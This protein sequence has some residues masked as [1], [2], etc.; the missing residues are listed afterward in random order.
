M[1]PFHG[2]SEIVSAIDAPIMAAI[3]GELSGSTDITVRLSTT[4]L[5]KSFGNSGRIGL[6]ITRAARTAFSLGRPSLLRK[7]PGILPTE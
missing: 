7:L 4:S 2:I 5:R 1:G 6:S 3:S